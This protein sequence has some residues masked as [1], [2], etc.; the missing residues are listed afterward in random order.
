MPKWRRIV[1]ACVLL[2]E[3]S[4]LIQGFTRPFPLATTP[5]LITQPNRSGTGGSALALTHPIHLTYIS[6]FSW[7]RVDTSTSAKVVERRQGSPPTTT[8]APSESREALCEV[9]DARITGAL[10]LD[11]SRAGLPHIAHYRVHHTVRSS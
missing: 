4:G 3:S 8:P 2:C 11:C 7:L 10:L 6:P 5:S 1:L 9:W